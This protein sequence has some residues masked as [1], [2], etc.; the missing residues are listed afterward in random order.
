MIFLNGAVRC[1]ICN[2]GVNQLVKM[3]QKPSRLFLFLLGVILVLNLLQA[4]FTELIFDEAYY[5]YYSQ[6]LDWGY[7][8]HP[9][10]VAWLIKASSYFFDGELGVRFMSCIFI[11]G[12][13]YYFMDHRRQYQKK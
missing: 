12:Y 11:S 6:N 5:W 7:F 1:R 13:L 3:L 4:Y 2:F 10:M 9:P 8:D